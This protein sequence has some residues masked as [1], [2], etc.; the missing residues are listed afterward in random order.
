MMRA[1]M[2]AWAALFAS[3]ASTLPAQTDYRNLDAGRPLRAEDALV[4]P[5][6][7]LDVQLPSLR[8][9]RFGSGVTRWRLE[10]KAAFGVAP[11]TEIELRVPYL[12][13]VPPSGSGGTRTHGLA[14]VAVSMV[15]AFGVETPHHPALAVATEA[16]LPAGTLAAPRPSYSLKAIT[17]LTTSVARFNLNAGW[18]G[19]SVRNVRADTVC[20]RRRFPLPGQ[21]PGCGAPIIQD[22]PCTVMPSGVSALCMGAPAIAAPDTSIGT[23]THWS[24]VASADHAFGLS[25]TLVGWSTGRRNWAS[26]A[27]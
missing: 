9:E 21:D 15:H 2:F 18:S 4:V 23:G 16:L 20:V 13:V 26:D 11:F 27:N 1:S 5:R 8:I 24:L 25:S 12:E 10:P 22:F 17:S 6:W 3:A 14:G 7:A 19:Y